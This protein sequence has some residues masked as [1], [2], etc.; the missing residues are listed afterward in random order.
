ML[1]HIR[2][3]NARTVEL[4]NRGVVFAVNTSMVAQV[5]N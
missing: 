4:M 5:Y 3:F 2:T 1:E